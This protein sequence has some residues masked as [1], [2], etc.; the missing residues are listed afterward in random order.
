[1]VQCRNKQD[2]QLSQKDPAAG[3]VIVFAISGRL[4]LGYN[5]LQTL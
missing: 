1:M 3:C 4:E 2:A 5:I